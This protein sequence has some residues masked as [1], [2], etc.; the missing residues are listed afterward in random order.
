MTRRIILSG[1]LEIS[2]FNDA[3]KAM[4]AP[5]TPDNEDERI[6]A[7]ER[8]NILDTPSEIDF[9]NITKLAANICQVPI[10][11]ISF[12]DRER[13]WF[14][15][16][17]G[18]NVSEIDRCISFCG[19]AINSIGEIMQI[20]DATVDPRFCNNPLVTNDP[21]IKFYAGVV[22]KGKNGMPL[23]TLCVLDNNPT[24]L[25][26]VQTESLKL[27]ALQVETLL[28][29]R[30]ELHINDGVAQ[31]DG[32]E[33]ISGLLE[34]VGDMIFELNEKGKFSYVNNTMSR[35]TGMSVSKL[36]NTH[37]WEHIA[38][39]QK[40]KV[41]SHYLQLIREKVVSDYFEFKAVSKN[42]YIW[43]GQNVEIEY[44]GKRVKHAYVVTRDITE[45]YNAR[46]MLSRSERQ[47]RLLSENSRDFISLV[48]AKGNYLYVSSS[49]KELLGYEPNH[50]I[51]T[52]VFDLTHK[53]DAVILKKQR[54][55]ENKEKKNLRFATSRIRKKDGSYLWME[56]IIK[57]I[58]DDD[59]KISSYQISARDISERKRK[60]DQLERKQA[61]LESLIKN[62]KHA[63]AVLDY[64]GKHVS[65]NE[66]YRSGM[67]YY[68]GYCPEIG[69][70]LDFKKLNKVFFDFESLI[71][72]A[73][74]KKVSRKLS[75]H[76]N[77]LEH[78]LI[79]H[80]GPIR[81]KT[82]KVAG[83]MLEIRDITAKVREKRKSEQH[84][85]ALKKLNEIITA[86]T[87]KNE[88]LTQALAISLEYLELDLGIVSVINGDDYIIYN[89]LSKSEEFAI[90]NG[91]CL[92]L[93]NTYCE[94]V[95]NCDDTLT[96]DSS[97]EDKYHEHPCYKRMGLKTFLGTSYYVGDE[98]RGTVSFSS[99][100]GRN[101]PFSN[102]EIEFVNLFSRWTG[103]LIEREEFRQQ[104]M[105][106]RTVLKAFVFSA[107]AAI[108]MLNEKLEYLAV[109]DQW[110]KEYKLENIQ[111][112]GNNYGIISPEL[113]HHWDSKLQLCLSGVIDKSEG[114]RIKL[115]GREEQWLKWEVRP[116]VKTDGIVGGIIMF[117][118]DI[119]ERKKQ[120]EELA[121]ARD[122]AEQAS[123]AKEKFLA[124]MSHEIRTPMNAII[125]AISL[126]YRSKPTKD[127]LEN[128]NLLKYSSENLLSL[129]N[130]I[131]DFS[132]IEADKISLESIDFNLKHLLV[133]IKK[134]QQVKAEESG[135]DLV[136]KYDNKLPE[137]F[138]GDQMR[139]AQVILNLVSNAIKFTYSGYVEVSAIMLHMDDN[140]CYIRLSVKDTGIGID[141]RKVAGVFNEFEQASEEVTRKFGGTGLGLAISKRL[142]G[143]MGAE[144]HVE[145]ELNHGSV[146]SFDIQLPYKE[147]GKGLRKRKD[148]V[149]QKKLKKL[150]KNKIHVL[151]AEDNAGNRT[152]LE[153]IL[154]TWNVTVDFAPDGLVAIEKIKNKEYNIVLM[155]I[156]M[157]EVD[158]YTAAKTIRKMSGSYFQNIPILALSAFTSAD[159]Q[160]KVS[161]C[162]M[163]DYLSKPIKTE[164][165]HRSLVKYAG[166]IDES[167]STN[168]KDESNSDLAKTFPYIY[169]ITDG[170]Q[171]KVIDI[172]ETIIKTVPHELDK[173]RELNQ[174]G[175][176][177]ELA[178]K[179]HKIKPNL[180]SL[181]L[182]AL[183][184][185][186]DKLE[187]AA[188]EGLIT[189]LNAN[190]E[191]F[192]ENVSTSLLDAEQKGAG[193]LASPGI[194]KN[195]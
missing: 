194:P 8:T 9:E 132:K 148:F 103:F 74:E 146:F 155:D 92:S 36:L 135:L 136:L 178:E 20:T 121:N 116:W 138:V 31:G 53:A 77:G 183:V 58:F 157:P 181:E 3:S 30:F 34:R 107:P 115:E 90:K 91:D 78:H 102:Q 112:L 68:A 73:H 96:I 50:L 44:S 28:N 180:E 168:K 150:G 147:K 40:D 16:H 71:G 10:S 42:G 114:E 80:C 54:E 38:P 18:L 106:E 125:G 173:I 87:D 170:N 85:E 163:N 169:Q 108:A 161:E 149:T 22:I 37:F 145:S 49:V 5:L 189:D 46:E 153:K 187:E 137:V 109:S 19:H 70:T 2:I 110:I 129:I 105:S 164:D 76:I 175:K 81:D 83:L 57:A 11:C 45:L 165:L 62:S 69:Q 171:E 195:E 144:I 26:K 158:G 88:Q 193:L 27:L 174:I 134:S 98:K 67:G 192:I 179:I 24:E 65:F 61:K 79:G 177:E 86:D 13:V 59:G 12:V 89:S 130:D 97:N 7:L 111:V 63:I 51:G 93:K 154:N 4:I 48:D 41:V 66:V 159:V 176:Y 141:A 113:K 75:I 82:G 124:T 131:L 190:L 167:I 191:E 72:Q 47:Y 17:N 39:E 100:K 143:L 23:G 128:L 182:I 120:A 15:S 94:S 6:V 152:I 123:I 32:L 160:L 56:S 140:D 126:L 188:L 117:T 99:S 60:D 84:K 101:A 184:E 172:L 25:D 104:W 119:T 95:F 133:D 186:A 33:R 64:T 122:I 1:Q 118:E 151:A 185:M 35:I 21:Q 162:G 55:T 166:R 14:K 127:Q 142:I 29:T 52:N 43:V 156:Q 139:I